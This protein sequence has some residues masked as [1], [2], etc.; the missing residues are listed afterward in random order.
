MNGSILCMG[1]PFLRQS[2]QISISINKEEIQDQ[3]KDTQKRL[4]PN[5]PC[6]TEM[7]FYGTGKKKIEGPQF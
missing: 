3:E 4:Q 7:P 5:Q 2:P 1:S 6:K